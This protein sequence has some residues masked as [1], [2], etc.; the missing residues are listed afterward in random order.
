M[1]AVGVITATVTAAPGESKDPIANPDLAA[2]CGID[3][4][5]TLDRSGSIE[6]AGA[7]DDVQRAF[8]AFT[9]A[10][11][12]TGSR[13]AVSEFSTVARLPLLPPSAQSTYTTVTD[14]TIAST[15]E[16]Y[17]AGVRG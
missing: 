5:V 12:N 14:Q 7:E 3:I 8:R 17:I 11:K 6:N 16:P 10:L 1:V 2:A 13:L 15:F 9:S 4:L